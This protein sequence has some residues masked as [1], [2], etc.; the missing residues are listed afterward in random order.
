MKIRVLDV[1]EVNNYIKSVLSQNPILENIQ[2]R[3]EVSNFKVHYSGNVYLSLKDDKSKINCIIFKDSFDKDLDIKDGVKVVASGFISTYVRDGVY[4]LYIKKI[5]IEGQ[6]DL[7]YKFL[8]LKENL[9]KEGLFSSVHKKKICKFPRNIGV[10]TSATGA[11]IKDIINVVKRRY[12]KVNIKLYPVL[13]QG[14]GSSQMIEE[15]IRFFNEKRNVDTII[16]GRG[17]GS[18]EELW[19]FNE[20]NVA[21]AIFESEIPIISAVGHETDFTISDF[22]ADMRA[23]TPS[24]AAEIATPNIIDVI[25]KQNIL[26]DRATRSVESNIKIG[27][28]RLDM[29]KEIISNNIDK[30]IHLGKQNID[31]VMNRINQ[32]YEKEYFYNKRLELD[33]IKDSLDINIDNFLSKSRDKL[34]II[35]IS[36][37][38][39]NPFAVMQRGYAVV[40]KDGDLITS[41]KDVNIGDNINI[42]VNRG[43]VEA[44]VNNILSEEDV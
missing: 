2:V 31:Y 1:Y 41:V 34:N 9:E 40:E 3:G 33:S 42:K 25:K 28:Q 21:R 14:P 24:A 32:I 17:G 10:V 13:V 7:Y 36:L 43:S 26:L 19:S 39:L 37:G 20:E 38:N 4:Q 16:I 8:K 6:G 35:S 5:E 11:V 29:K 30:R 15:G 23:P 44:T 27:H 22:V 18:I 12:P